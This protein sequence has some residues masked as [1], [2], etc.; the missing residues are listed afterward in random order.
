MSIFYESPMIICAKC[1]YVSRLAHFPNLK[2]KYCS[3]DMVNTNHNYN[4][5]SDQYYATHPDAT[6]RTTTGTMVNDY[7]RDLVLGDTYDQQLH[8]AVET[9]IHEK[10]YGGPKCPKCGSNSIRQEKQGFKVGR[11]VVTTALTGFLDVGALAGAAGANKMVN[12]CNRCGH[13]WK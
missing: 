8:E 5:W 4:Y 11:A 1:G 7:V 9:Q 6:K 12:V 3:G 2:C 10:L 13:T